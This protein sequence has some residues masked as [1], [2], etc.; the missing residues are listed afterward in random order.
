[1]WLAGVGIALIPL[2]YGV[3]C[4][5]IG[6][7]RLL[8]SRGH[9]DLVGPAATALAIAYIAVG[10]FIHFHYFWGLHSR[11][12]RLSP[13]LKFITVLVFLGSFGYTMYRIIT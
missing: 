4:L 13:T 11:L 6:Q 10:A 9:L 7:A 2:G 1:M 8:G 3:R 5:L 12:L